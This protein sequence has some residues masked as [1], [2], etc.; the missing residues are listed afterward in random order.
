MELLNKDL[1]LLSDKKYNTNQKSENRSQ[2]TF[3]SL[4]KKNNEIN[5]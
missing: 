1:Y 4:F 5:I 3:L 2:K